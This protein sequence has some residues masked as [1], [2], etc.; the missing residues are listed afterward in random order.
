MTVFELVSPA[1]VWAFAV[2]SIIAALVH[3]ISGSHQK[4]TLTFV[5]LVAG[6]LWCVSGP[7]DEPFPG[8]LTFIVSV[9][10]AMQTIMA[11]VSYWVRDVKL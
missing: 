3:R 1:L 6:S 8:A 9:S 5:V 7:N 10:T 2:V 4:I 11:G